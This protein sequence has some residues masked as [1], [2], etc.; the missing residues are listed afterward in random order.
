MTI[1]IHLMPAAV[2]HHDRNKGNIARG[3]G[4]GG[5]GGGG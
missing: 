5:G 2:A 4:G 1:K 3:G